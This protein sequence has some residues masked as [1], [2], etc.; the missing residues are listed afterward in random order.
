MR[1]SFAFKN[2]KI[3]AEILFLWGC[4]RYKRVEIMPQQIFQTY[5]RA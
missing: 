1:Q 3:I 2:K 4:R 5:T